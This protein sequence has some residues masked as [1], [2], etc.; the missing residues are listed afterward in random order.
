[1]LYYFKAEAANNP[2]TYGYDARHLCLLIAGCGTEVYGLYEDFAVFMT[3]VHTVVN[4]AATN[5]SWL[6]VACLGG[7]R[8]LA[9]SRHALALRCASLAISDVRLSPRPL[10]GVLLPPCMP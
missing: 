2:Y 8:P 10:T 5:T 3:S 4:A 9:L 7:A 1:M 6:N